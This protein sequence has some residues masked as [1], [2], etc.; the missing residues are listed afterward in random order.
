[1]RTN[2]FARVSPRLALAALVAAQ[3]GAV[4]RAQQVA[5]SP[6]SQATREAPVVQFD[7][8]GVELAE[9]VRLTL[10]NSPDIKISQA[11][12]R[13]QLGVAQ[14]QM[15]VF[16]TVFT[17]GGSYN[18]QRQALTQSTILSETLKRQALSEEATNQQANYNSLQTQIATLKA[19]RNTAPGTLQLQQLAALDPA[20]A[21]NLRMIDTLAQL[22][23]GAQVTPQFL[24]NLKSERDDLINGA[25]DDA[26]QGSQDAQ[27]AYIQ[28]NTLATN[29]GSIPFQQWFRSSNANLT[30]TRLFRNGVTFSPY[31]TGDSNGTNY[32][33]KPFS[34]DF[35]GLGQYPL[36]TFK[37]GFNVVLPL[38]RGLGSAAVAAPERSSLLT[39][40]ATNL[41]VKQQ[42]STSALQTLQAYWNLR[43]AQE[44]VA[45]AQRSVDIQNQLVTLTEGSIAAGVQPQVELARVQA[46]QARSLAALRDAQS[47]VHSGR[48]ALATAMGISATV[49]EATLPRARDAF[50][51]APDPSAINSERLVALAVAAVG[52]RRDVEAAARRVE[53]ADVFERGARLNQRPVV[54][55][56]GGTWYTGIQEA[57]PGQA[58]GHWVGPSYNATLDVQKPFGNNAQKGQ[59]VQA[60]AAT[61]SAQINSAELKRQV[62]LNVLRDIRSMNE[63]AEQVKQAQAAVNFYQQTID[64]EVQR[65]QLGEVTLI[66]TITTE[67]QMTGARQALVA[68]E[69]ALANLIADLRFQTGTLVTDISA[70]I[71]PKTLVSVP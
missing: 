45:I 30:L 59:F 19:I 42:A 38:A 67:S 50:P 32:V 18:Y 24:S 14:Q 61:S 22:Q 52:Q 60:Q 43:A 41:D 31:F 66:D 3:S 36:Y 37:S 26:I 16:D 51:D 55:L 1:M 28:L 15:G 49:E 58:L 68:A 57:N 34:T 39:E 46:S 29:L 25:L 64:S 44:N 69:T 62:R 70:P 12:A 17:G 48:V 11:A 13:Q 5:M 63:A 35:G 8:Q 65:F 56:S 54:N 20:T 33:N 71:V 9:A 53:A 6:P 21:A 23:P 2:S 4:A 47:A 10:V 7:P 40:E 27:Q